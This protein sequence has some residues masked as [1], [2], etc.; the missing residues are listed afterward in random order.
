[1][2][3]AI[4]TVQ[5]VIRTFEKYQCPLTEKDVIQKVRK[6][7]D[8]KTTDA[9]IKNCLRYLSVNLKARTAWHKGARLSIDGHRY[10]RLY[11]N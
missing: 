8:V 11:Y 3:G 9:T 6:D 1:M 7:F 2:K 5:M 4:P 10:D